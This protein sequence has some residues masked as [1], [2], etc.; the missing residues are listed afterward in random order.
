[1]NVIHD[2]VKM[3]MQ[4]SV[5]H[6]T[7]IEEGVKI[8]NHVSIGNN[9]TIYAGVEIGDYV[10]IFDNAVIG[11]RPKPA[12]LSTVKVRKDLPPLI[13]GAGT[14]I[15]ANSVLYRGVTI[16]SEVMVGDLASIREQTVIGDQVVVGRGVAVENEVTIGSRTKIQ[17]NAYITAYTTIEEQVFIAPTVTTTNDN[18]MGRTKERFQS[19]RGAHIKKGAR[20]GGA[21]ILLPGVTVA[22]ESF[23]AAGALVSKDTEEETV[24]L[25][26][27]AKKLRAVPEKEKLKNQE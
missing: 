26:V 24:Y 13:I 8:G 25:G 7:V 19:I 15:G 3:G 27:P 2:S 4:V 23:I 12:K 10:T 6:F 16:G 5:G 9:V 14:T 11:R 21:S 17:T 22:E 18:F 1:M 20:V